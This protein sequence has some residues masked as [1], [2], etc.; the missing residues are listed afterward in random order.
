M[1]EDLVGEIVFFF[2]REF[3]PMAF[4]PDDSFFIIKPRHQSVFSIGGDRTL[5]LLYNY[6]RLY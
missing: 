3:Q 2:W 6:Q 5:D 1:L 4:V